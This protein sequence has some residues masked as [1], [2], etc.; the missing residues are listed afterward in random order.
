MVL[1]G[2]AHF[3]NGIVSGRRWIAERACEFGEGHRVAECLD[4]RVVHRAQGFG[5]RTRAIDPPAHRHDARAVAHR[6]AHGLRAAVRDGN[7]DENVLGIRPSRKR[8]LKRREE[9]A[10][11][12]R[13]AAA[14]DV[15]RGCAKLRGDV[16]NPALRCARHGD[17]LLARAPD[18]ARSGEGGFPKCAALLQSGGL[19]EF[20]LGC[21]PCGVGKRHR[22]QRAAHAHPR[23]HVRRA[24][25]LHKNSERP[26]VGNRVV[27]R[28]SQH[29]IIR[30]PPEH[31]DAVQRPL[32]EIEWLVENFPRQFLDRLRFCLSGGKIADSEIHAAAFPNHLHR[33][34]FSR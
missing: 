26:A 8:R 30:C 4:G 10:E 6:L 3:K 16:R 22:R 21:T 5:K 19:P 20:P 28:E 12:R 11:Q 29:E 7:A 24:Q 1:Q 27:N 17:G 33:P 32:H 31:R 18:P 25:V 13:A 23:L 2:E 14:G 15:A 34:V 9:R